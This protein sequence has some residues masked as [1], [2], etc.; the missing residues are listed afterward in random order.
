MSYD[1]DNDVRKELPKSGVISFSMLFI[2]V[3][4]MIL[5]AGVAILIL[6]FSDFSDAT[7]ITVL[8]ADGEVIEQPSE[9]QKSQEDNMRY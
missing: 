3:G 9:E 2:W 6:I 4:L 8:S 1:Y 5:A 7:K